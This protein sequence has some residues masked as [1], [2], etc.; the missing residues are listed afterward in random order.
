M[1]REN[2]GFGS[3]GKWSRGQVALVGKSNAFAIKLELQLLW[4][5]FSL[6][7]F[8]ERSMV[9]HKLLGAGNQVLWGNEEDSVGEH[10]AVL[11]KWEGMMCLYS[12]VQRGDAR[13]DAQTNV[14]THIRLHFFDKDSTS[15]IKTIMFGFKTT[16]EEVADF[17]SPQVRGKHFVI[18][19]GNSGLGAETVRVL[20][21]NGGIVTLC[22]RTV[23]KGVEVRDAILREFPS[24]KVSV[25][26]L[27]LRT[28]HLENS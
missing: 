8:H 21:K 11:D 23:S 22:C 28:S 27:D 10:D 13:G 5:F 12:D 25:M 26:Q 6:E 7:L 2:E 24:A 14:E 18:T 16:A 19:G 17:F 4:L 3:I 20:A 9:N 1:D 15:L